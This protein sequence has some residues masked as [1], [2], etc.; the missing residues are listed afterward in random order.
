MFG[1]SGLIKQVVNAHKCNKAKLESL[2]VDGTLELRCSIQGTRWT[3]DVEC[4]ALSVGRRRTE[5]QR[6]RRTYGVIVRFLG[7]SQ[8]PG[9]KFT[10]VGT[11]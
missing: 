9:H 5:G 3:M 4:W 11:E 2:Q 10:V 1:E 8:I 6:D 7:S